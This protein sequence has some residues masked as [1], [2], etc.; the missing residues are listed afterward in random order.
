MYSRLRRR[1]FGEEGAIF[2]VVLTGDQP[3]AEK[4]CCKIGPLDHFV[5][6]LK[7]KMES[8][9]RDA[10]ISSPCGVLST[11]ISLTSPSILRP[12][13]LARTD[14]KFPFPSPLRHTP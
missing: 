8:L 9:L 11:I 6:F 10:K 1:N 3:D 7:A 13:S 12:E 14:L 4:Q 5:S 2:L